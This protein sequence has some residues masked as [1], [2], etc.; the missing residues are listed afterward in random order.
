MKLE[1]SGK[2]DPRSLALYKIQEGRVLLE[3]DDFEGSRE[4]FNE[5][6]LIYDKMAVAYYFIGNSYSQESDLAY[7]NEESIQISNGEALKVFHNQGDETFEEVADEIGL[8]NENIESISILVADYDNDGYLDLIV[9][10]YN[11]DNF[12]YKNKN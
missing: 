7:K 3:E 2:N 1:Y 4:C 5:A 10:N 6:I 11:Q 12:L 9:A 8:G